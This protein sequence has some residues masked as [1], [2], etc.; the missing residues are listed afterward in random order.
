MS[1]FGEGHLCGDGLGHRHT[2]KAMND[3]VVSFGQG[4]KVL[5]REDGTTL[6]LNFGGR[7]RTVPIGVRWLA[8]VTALFCMLFFF[9]SFYIPFCTLSW[10]LP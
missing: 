7:W 1:L 4:I 2:L 6:A 10:A 3:R 8:K 9:L 5:L